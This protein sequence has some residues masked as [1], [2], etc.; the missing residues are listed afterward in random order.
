[1]AIAVPSPSLAELKFEVLGEEGSIAHRSACQMRK[2][3]TQLKRSSCWGMQLI[4]SHCLGGTRCAFLSSACAVGTKRAILRALRIPADI[5]RVVYWMVSEGYICFGS[6]AKNDGRGKM[7]EKRQ[8]E[9]SHHL[10]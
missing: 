3:K 7:I 4:N 8:R 5:Q 10:Q 2:T 6:I 1:M 9:K